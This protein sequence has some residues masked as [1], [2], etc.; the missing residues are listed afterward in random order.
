MRVGLTEYQERAILRIRTICTRIHG[1]AGKCTHRLI[2]LSHRSTFGTP[3]SPLWRS[4][5]GHREG[6]RRS[7]I[8][9]RCLS[10]PGGAHLA[11]LEWQLRNCC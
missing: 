1:S 2:R 9:P 11:V 7:V 8:W 6:V 3:G 5:T 4:T 10:R